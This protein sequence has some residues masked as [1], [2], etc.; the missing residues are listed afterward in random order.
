MSHRILAINPGS[1]S[2]KVAVYDEGEPVFN[3]SLAH[4]PSDLERFPSVMDLSLIHI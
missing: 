3:I 1:T 4:T 2:T